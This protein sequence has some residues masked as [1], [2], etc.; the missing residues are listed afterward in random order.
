[1]S[2]GALYNRPMMLDGNLTLTVTDG[3]GNIKAIRRC[4][5]NINGMALQYIASAFM[6]G[7]AITFRYLYVASGM[8][9]VPSQS[10]V[11]ACSQYGTICVTAHMPLSMVYNW[12]TFIPGTTTE[13]CLSGTLSFSGETSK[14]SLDAAWIAAQAAGSGVSNTWLAQASFADLAVTSVDKLSFVWVF[15]LST[16]TA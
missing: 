6:N 3:D 10:M 8:N 16:S 12:A 5:N 11:W 15:S 4:H 14:T 1:M 13:W 7:D 2:I 9:G